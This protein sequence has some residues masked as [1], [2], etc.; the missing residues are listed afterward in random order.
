MNKAT[1]RNVADAASVSLA[2][3]SLAL[4]NHGRIAERTRQKVWDA[5]R[6]LGYE[7]RHVPKIVEKRALKRVGVVTIVYQ[8]KREHL[9][10]YYTRIL[11]GIEEECRRHKLSI[12]FGSVEVDENHAAVDW[13]AMLTEEQVDGI[14]IV[15]AHLKSPFNRIRGLTEK[16]IVLAN[17]YLDEASLDAVLI[18]NGMGASQAVKFL[19]SYGHLHIGCIGANRRAHPAV[20]ERLEAYSCTVKELRLSEYVL[21]TEHHPSQTNEATLQLLNTHPEISAIFA[22]SDVAAAGV[23]GGAQKAGRSVPKT[24]SIVGFDDLNICLLVSP[25]L[26]TIHVDIDLIGVLS[27]RSLLNRVADPSHPPI[28]VRIGTRLIERDSVAA[29]NIATRH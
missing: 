20:V 17:S 11:A 5:A 22:C 29:W 26:S 14:I 18:E 25:A 3:A 4:N 8:S 16:P 9:T 10:E 6:R 2:T 19:F 27:V 7:T 1:L 12:M 23:L 28:T 13:P 15:G 21:E 24:L